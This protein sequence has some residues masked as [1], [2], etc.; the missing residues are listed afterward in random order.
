MVKAYLLSKNTALRIFLECIFSLSLLVRGLFK[1]LV[2]SNAIVKL[3][4]KKYNTNSAD[5]NDWKRNAT[6]NNI[7]L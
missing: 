2:K 6:E 7:S 5:E 1:H 4:R 3:A